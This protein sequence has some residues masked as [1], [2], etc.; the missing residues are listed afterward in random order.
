MKRTWF[1]TV[2]VGV[3]L[4]GFGLW[5]WLRPPQLKTVEV[6]K[7]VTKIVEKPVERVVTPTPTGTAT[8]APTV[9]GTS[10]PAMP[11]SAPAGTSMASL[12][13][14]KPVSGPSCRD[15]E[16]IGN[17][18]ANLSRI[19]VGTAENNVVLELSWPGKGFGGFD[20]AVVVVPQLVNGVQVFV[21]NASTIH[22]VLYCGTL[23]QVQDY[24]IHHVEAMVVTAAD[25]QGRVPKTTEIAVLRLDLNTG[26]LFPLVNA[27]DGPEIST[28]QSHFEVVRLSA[29]PTPTVVP[30]STPTS[31]PTSI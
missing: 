22:M 29:K 6:T 4:L 28:V 25:S 24:A 17:M 9:T 30:T 2:L 13:A 26:K 12:T 5:G 3:V 23:E 1:V 20:R 16:V 18:Y 14:T 31:T 11:T 8:P 7:E 19:P 27:P 21:K 15:G 10:L